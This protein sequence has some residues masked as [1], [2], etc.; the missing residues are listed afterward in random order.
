MD[1]DAL[2][3]DED[4]QGV[5]ADPVERSPAETNIALMQPQDD[6]DHQKLHAPDPGT[7]SHVQRQL[8][9]VGVNV[10][11]FDRAGLAKA[12]IDGERH[13]GK[14]E[15]Q[16]IE[17]IPPLGA[18]MP[19]PAIEKTETAAGHEEIEAGI[20]LIVGVNVQ[21]HPAVDMA[22]QGLYTELIQQQAEHGQYQHAANA[23]PAIH[24]REECQQTHPEHHRIEGDGLAEVG[25][26][27]QPLHIKHGDDADKQ[28]QLA[29]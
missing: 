9:F 26:D 14:G 22:K 28:H 18:L 19:A 24:Q 12:Q 21:L 5:H 16:A 6:A 23:K 4:G 2:V 15:H 7:A 8:M 1:E 20:Q 3:E 10:V 11:E 27:D 17:A 29:F 25:G 13:H